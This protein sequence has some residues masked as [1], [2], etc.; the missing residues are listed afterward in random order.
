MPEYRTLCRFIGMGQLL[1]PDVTAVELRKHDRVLMCSDGL[2]NMLSNVDI[3]DALLCGVSCEEACSRLIARANQAG[4]YDNITVIVA[5][6]QST[7]SLDEIGGDAEGGGL[8]M[9]MYK[10]P[11]REIAPEGMDHDGLPRG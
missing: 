1:P 2:T 5:D 7:N 11:C 6:V 8:Q 3:S 4:G 10:A 9:D